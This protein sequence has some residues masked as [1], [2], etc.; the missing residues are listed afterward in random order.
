HRKTMVV[1]DGKGR[2]AWTSYQV[3]E[4]LKA[5]TLVEVHLHTG[6]THQI[7]VHFQHIGFPL[8]GD[9]IYGKR[10]NKRLAELTGF[11]GT[12]QM[13]HSYRQSFAHPRTGERVVCV[14]P[15]PGDFEGALERLRETK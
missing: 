13:L 6:R 10:S 5:A 3:K 15:L 8:V 2:E 4:R 12:R 1:T 11:T 7:R 14:A 9:A